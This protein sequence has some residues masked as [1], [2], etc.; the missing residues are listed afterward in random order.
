[1]H[2]RNSSI[3]AVIWLFASFTFA[4]QEESI[5]QEQSEQEGRPSI[6]NRWEDGKEF[7]VYLYGKVVFEDGTP[8]P[9]ELTV[10]LVCNGEVSKQATVTAKGRFT[11]SIEGHNSDG[12][13][14]D[15]SNSGSRGEDGR[16]YS[17]L[18]RG[19]VSG[20]QL[21]SSP[22]GAVNLNGCEV[23]LSPLAGYIANTI[24]LNSRGVVDNPEIGTIVIRRQEHGLEQTVEL[25]ELSIP[26]KAVNSY[27]KA[28][29]Q[30]SRR[31][32][33]YEKAARELEKAVAIFPDYSKAWYLLGR[34]RVVL[35]QPDEARKAFR[36]A[37]QSNSKEPGPFLD[38]AQI[39]LKEHRWLEASQVMDEVLDLVSENPRAHYF[40]GLAKFNLDEYSEAKRSFLVVEQLGYCPNYPMS[41]FYM[42]L[43]DT[44]LGNISLAADEFRKFLQ[45]M[46]A[47][48]LP[49]E[50]KN[51]LSFQIKDWEEK[52][53]TAKLD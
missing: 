6:E 43:I 51:K 11:I 49:E 14:M 36:T 17:P 21:K 31:N 12:S 1:M 15:A 19:M 24:L 50:L 48:Q 39:E 46:P 47:E 2:S 20:D 22:L 45:V 28:R 13:L 23:K 32:T 37:I 38:L 9:Q 41:Y 33:D 25:A 4:Q 3:F 5:S 7:V 8:I 34:V 26:K 27:E 44:N 16:S 52:G 18:M 40:N 35:N 29:K 53:L 30:L 42:G 10:D